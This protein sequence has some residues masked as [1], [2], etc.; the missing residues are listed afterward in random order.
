MIEDKEH[1][2]K[3]ASK[4]EAFWKLRLDAVEKE[5]QSAKDALIY[6]EAIADMCRIK[7]NG[8]ALQD[9]GT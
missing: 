1:G 6:L 2:I 9:G 3:I 8:E 7:A 5:I 4:K